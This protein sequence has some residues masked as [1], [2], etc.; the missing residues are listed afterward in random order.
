MIA[1][2]TV[3]GES[4]L[5]FV[6]MMQPFVYFNMIPSINDNYTIVPYSGYNGIDANFQVP[7]SG[8]TNPVS[9]FVPYGNYLG[10]MF[11]EEDNIKTENGNLIYLQHYYLWCEEN[12]Q[13]G[14]FIS[15]GSNP[16]GYLNTY[17]I[18]H[19]SGWEQLGGFTQYELE[20]VVGS[21]GQGTVA[22]NLSDGS[23]NY[24]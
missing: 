12:L 15:W 4:L 24:Q 7:L 9:G 10:I 13:P 19:T 20:R 1:S 14:N 18:K 22:S 21:D 23:G 6:E 16:G 17:R 11:N 8:L 2:S 3:Y 5:S